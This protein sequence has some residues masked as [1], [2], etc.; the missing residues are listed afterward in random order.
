MIIGRLSSC[1]LW[2]LGNKMK[3]KWRL[4]PFF[5]IHIP[6]RRPFCL[7]FH[8]LTSS[9]IRSTGWFQIPF[10]GLF[11][12]SNA[13]KISLISLPR[14]TLFV[15]VRQGN[16]FGFNIISVPQKSMQAP[17]SAQIECGQQQCAG[18]K[19]GGEKA[20][21]YSLNITVPGFPCC[22]ST[23]TRHTTCTWQG[24]GCAE[25]SLHNTLK[26]MLKSFRITPSPILPGC[27]PQ[28]F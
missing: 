13:R 28:H 24:E 23:E 7:Q 20:L 4:L 3:L 15:S 9:T 27:F 1:P 11:P 6:C 19:S 12:P 21:P 22:L 18:A 25:E 14:Y 17:F 8:N 26:T 10:L 16:Q 2:V 5:L